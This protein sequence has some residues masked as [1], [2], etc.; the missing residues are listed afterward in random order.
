MSFFRFQENT[1]PADA[2]IRHMD[3]L[4]RP[5]LHSV[6]GFGAFWTFPELARN[7]LLKHEDRVVFE[8]PFLPPLLATASPDDCKAIFTDRE[9]L[10]FGEALRRMAPHEMVFGSEMIDWWNGDN[11]MPLRR[12]VMPAF[13]G[14][15]LEGYEEAMIAAASLR[16]A[17]WPVDA[18]VSFSKLM[19]A[20]ARDVIMSVVFGVTEEKRRQ[21]LE[22]A[23]ID[24]DE[25]LRSPG[26]IGRYFLAMGRGGKWPRFQKLDAINA[27]IDAITQE[28]IDHRRAHPQS[29]ERKDCL[30]IFLRIQ[31]EDKDSL[32]NDRMIAVFQRLLLIAGYETTAVTLAW[33]AERLVRHPLIMARLEASLAR[34]EDKYLDAVITEV[35][36]LRPA[37]PVTLRYAE[38]D[39]RMNDVLVKAGTVIMVYINAVHKRAD[40]Y[41]EPERFDPERF[42]EARPHPH[43]WLPFGGG[44]HRCLGGAFAMVEARVLLR[45]ILKHRRFEADT[46]PDERVDQHR[47]IL[48]LPHRGAM[49]TLRRREPS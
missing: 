18:P 27:K 16:I 34:G 30:A 14:A 39:F 47:N 1:V 15:A 26:M 41:P 2:A 19:H 48:M 32:M 38:K 35:M 3:S 42:L 4:P 7:W 9:C 20:L 13:D 5:P 10:R 36:R 31:A 24:L 33:V 17:E 40:V 12:K 25:A 49:V 22:H 44:A 45:T 37:L 28:E 21:R 6:L 8:V 23:F 11:H 29:A 46:S 43:R